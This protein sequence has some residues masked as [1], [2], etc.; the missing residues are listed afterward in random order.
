M[1]LTDD[2]D[3]AGYRH[4]PCLTEARDVTGSQQEDDNQVLGVQAHTAATTRSAALLLGTYCCCDVLADRCGVPFK[5][6]SC[7][8]AVPFSSSAV[9]ASCSWVLTDDSDSAGYRA[10]SMPQD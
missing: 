7:V 9:P 4:A 10:R 2:S 8:S 3:S 1:V 5:R 6:T